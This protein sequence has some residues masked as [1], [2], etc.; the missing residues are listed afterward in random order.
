MG[1]EGLGVGAPHWVPTGMGTGDRVR[2]GSREQQRHNPLCFNPAT[3][4][5]ECL[6]PNTSLGDA[7]GDLGVL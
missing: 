2:L 7:W 6:A 1:L 4:V 5:W 3:K